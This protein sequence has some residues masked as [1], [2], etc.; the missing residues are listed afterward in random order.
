MY[1][2]KL[3]YIFWWKLVIICGDITALNSLS[4]ALAPEQPVVMQRLMPKL[5]SSFYRIASDGLVKKSAVEWQSSVPLWHRNSLGVTECL[6]PKLQSSFYRIASAGLVKKSAV[7]WQSSV[8]LW[9]RNSLGVTGRLMQKLQSGFCRV[10]SA[11][12]VK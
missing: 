8:P 2:K 6:M 5:Q 9:H 12:L 3:Y 7:E 4:F 11:G 10:G 1:S